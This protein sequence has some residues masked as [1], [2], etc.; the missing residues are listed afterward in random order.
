MEPEPE[1]GSAEEGI[2][3]RVLT[4]ADYITLSSIIPAAGFPTP[5]P[6]DD[7]FLFPRES[8]FSTQIVKSGSAVFQYLADR[9]QQSLPG[10]TI[11]NVR[12]FGERGLWDRFCAT[13]A[14]IQRRHG[15]SAISQLL[16][17]ATERPDY[18]TGTGFGE[19]GNGFDPTPT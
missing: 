3:P 18:I 5:I 1:E 6:R 11:V 15:D 4:E 7:P 9:V 14:S 19:N 12:R 16:F 17:H 8:D 13:K 2:P 10:A